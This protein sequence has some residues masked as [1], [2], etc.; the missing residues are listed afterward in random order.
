MKLVS[1]F[2]GLVFGYAITSP[3]FIFMEDW[4]MEIIVSLSPPEEMALVLLVFWAE[5]PKTIAIGVLLTGISLAL[6]NSKLLLAS[7]AFCT[8][9]LV[10]SGAFLVSASQLLEISLVKGLNATV[11]AFLIGLVLFY[12]TRKNNNVKT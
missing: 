4:W 7:T 11:I 5:L 12:K 6:G 10:I 3:F 8:F 9:A 2:F 1:I